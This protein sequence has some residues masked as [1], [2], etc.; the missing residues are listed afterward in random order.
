[1]HFI[2]ERPSY[3]NPA[4]IVTVATCAAAT[5]RALFSVLLRCLATECD[6]E[7]FYETVVNFF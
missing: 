1:M 6:I 7:P 5:S 3:L 4:N 2:T